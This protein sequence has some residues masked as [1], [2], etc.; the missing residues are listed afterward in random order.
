MKKKRC[1]ILAWFIPLNSKESWEIKVK[2]LAENRL[3]IW[4]A[5]H[6]KNYTRVLLLTYQSKALERTPDC[7]VKMKHKAPAN[8]I[9]PA[10]HQH[11]SNTSIV[12]TRKSIVSFNYVLYEIE[13]Q[14]K[15]L[16]KINPGL[17]KT[18]WG[19]KC[20]AFLGKK[21]KNRNNIKKKGPHRVDGPQTDLLNTA[22]AFQH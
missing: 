22:V 21:K 9:Q 13:T 15:H 5:L 18:Q 8:E 7:G 20:F 4:L 17:F 1:R 2:S 10:I 11:Q 3:V 16:P 14:M 12:S 6:K 19:K